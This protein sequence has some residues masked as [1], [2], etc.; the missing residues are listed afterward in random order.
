MITLGIDTATELVSVAVIDGGNLL[1]ASESLSD[2]RHAEDLTPMLQFVVQRAGIS[3]SEIDAV[4]VDVGPGLFT[5][6]RVGI[7]A[8]QALAQVLS[9]P[10][11]GVDSL[12]ALVAGV[13]SIDDDHELIVPVVDTRRREV[14]WALHRTHDD[15]SFRRVAPPHLGSLED[16]LAV[17]RERSQ[18]CLFVGAYALKNRE[19]VQADLGPQ[20]WSVR[21]DS[22][23]PHP[24]ARQV[25]AVGHARLL[26]ESNVDGEDAVFA[27]TVQP[28]Y[29][30]DADAEIH[31]ATRD[32]R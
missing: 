31:W 2:R 12:E 5:G 9:V 8:A 28:M 16:L 21:F 15:R 19:K 23:S 7:A 10:L 11:V 26:R 32:T 22:A 1:A 13:G 24:H 27:P 17:V 20:A 14:A 3:F 29:L 6:M 18:P 25:A 4:A 30:R